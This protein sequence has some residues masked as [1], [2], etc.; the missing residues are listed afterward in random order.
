MPIWLP[1]RK[2]SICRD[3]F[4]RHG[5]YYMMLFERAALE[6]RVVAEMAS[7]HRAI[8]QALI[9][10]EW[11]AAGQA[12]VRHIRAQRPIMRKLL[13]AVTTE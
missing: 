12:L 4:E 7:Q 1:R 9:E 6:T 10:Q 2:I 11:Q 13:A 5:V 3:F 8:L